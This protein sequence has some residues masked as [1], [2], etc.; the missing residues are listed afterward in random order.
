MAVAH[1]RL[2]ITRSSHPEFDYFL[3][4]R[5]ADTGR[6]VLGQHRIEDQKPVIIQFL[7]DLRTAAQRV[8]SKLTVIDETGEII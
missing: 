1:A 8:S 4:L 3:D 7:E 5:D 6:Q 2:T